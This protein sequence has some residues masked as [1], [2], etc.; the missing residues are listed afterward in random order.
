[1]KKIITALAM[2]PIVAQG[3]DQCVIQD[4]TVTSH[5]VEIAERSPVRRDLVPDPTGRKCV[6]DFR[7]RIG[8]EWH[9]AFGE[10]TWSGDRPS[11]EAC[12]IAVDR[13]EADVRQ[14]VGRGR[15]ISE[16]ILV[17]KDRPELITLLATPSGTMGDISQ[18]RPH[19]EHREKFYHNGTVCRW[20]VETNF[21]SR[22]V[23]T[24]QGIICQVSPSK[25]VV[26]DKF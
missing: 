6:V 16:R 10:Y 3:S 1:M 14:R 19:P 25:W 23:R 22:D 4:R 21:V 17:C 20:F 2:I 8:S 7:V 26:V 5:S 11:S 24:F 15:A 13:A 9:S 18:F 12:A